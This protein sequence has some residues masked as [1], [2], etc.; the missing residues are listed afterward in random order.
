MAANTLRTK[1]SKSAFPYLSGASSSLFELL[2][3]VRAFLQN[4][5]ASFQFISAYV[6]LEHVDNKVSPGDS[7]LG[8]CFLDRVQ[9]P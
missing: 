2:N 3:Q 4:T 8:P 7:L 9:M 5:K 1:V 6:T